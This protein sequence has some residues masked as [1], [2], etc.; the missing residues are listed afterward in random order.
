VIRAVFFDVDGV[1]VPPWRFRDLLVREHG[2]GPETTAAFFRGPFVECVLG[3]ARLEVV[4]APYLESWGWKGS[5]DELVDFWFAAENALDTDVLHL[6]AELR[7]RGMP[8]FV[9]STQER[10]RA[11]YLAGDMG[12]ARRF[13]ALFFS[14]DVGSKKPDPVFFAELSRRTAVPPASALLIDDTPANVEGARAAGW[15]ALHFRDMATLREQLAAL[16]LA[17]GAA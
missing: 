8:C 2:I 7:Q 6:A 10:L 15:Q 17:P 12:L 11:R 1:L 5:L 9:A 13:D 16:E 4:L 3:R 14:C